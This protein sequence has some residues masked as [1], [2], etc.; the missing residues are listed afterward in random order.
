VSCMLEKKNACARDVKR[1]MRPRGRYVQ[2]NQLRLSE[3]EDR[4][5]SCQLTLFELG[6]EKGGVW[7]CVISAQVGGGDATKA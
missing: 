2:Q 1:R 7:G 5:P 4:T 3:S 6:V